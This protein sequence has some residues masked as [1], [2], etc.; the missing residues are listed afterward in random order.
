MYKAQ[1]QTALSSEDAAGT[2][3]SKDISTAVL[4]FISQVCNAYYALRK[5]EDEMQQC[6]RKVMK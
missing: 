4:S 3:E 1:M 6:E 5:Q 2:F